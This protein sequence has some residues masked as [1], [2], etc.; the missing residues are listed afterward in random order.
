MLRPYS[1]KS[2]LA[3]LI[4]VNF[5]LLSG[6]ILSSSFVSAVDDTVIDDINISI[7]LAC[8]INGSG[9]GS[10][11]A[12]INNGTYESDIGT[13]TI[14]AFCNDNEGFSIYA[15]GY[16]DNS[17]GKNVLS[18]VSLGSTYDIATG[19]GTSG[20]SQW[21]VKLATN[22][23]A[24]YPITLQNNYGAYHTIPSDYELVA[25]RTSNT[26][27]GQ[28]AIGA[29]LS[30]TYQVFISDSQP[31]GRYVGKVKYVMVHPHDTY[32]GSKDEYEVIYDGSGST[33]SNGDRTNK[34]VYEEECDTMYERTAPTISKTSNMDNEG[35]VISSLTEN[36]DTL[37]PIT[38]SGANMLKI[39]L[40]YNAGDSICLGVSE[41]FIDDWDY[42]KCANGTYDYYHHYNYLTSGGSAIKTFY[43]DGD[44]VTFDFVSSGQSYSSNNNWGYF[45]QVYPIYETQRT[46]TQEASVCRISST[47]K[48]GTYDTTVNWQ[49]QWYLN[50]NG[51]EIITFNSESDVIE[52]LEINQPNSTGATIH[53]YAY[54]PYY[55]TYDGNNATA[56]NMSTYSQT[57]DYSFNE[58]T[59][60]A[61]NFYKTNYGF[62]GWS[63][64]PNATVN[65]VNKIFGPNETIA[66]SELKAHN[67]ILYAV[68]VQTA[69]TLQ[70]WSG[71][72]GLSEGQVTALTDSRDGQTYAVAK[73]DDGNCW[74][75]E[76]L[77]LEATN[78][79]D[80]TKAQGFGGGFSGLANPETSNFSNTSTANSKYSSSNI[81]STNRSYRFPRYNNTNITF[82]STSPASNDSNIYG[83]GNYYT[84]AAAK[85]NISDLAS[86]SDSM[87][88]NTSICPSGW[89]LPLT[90]TTN[91][92]YPNNI[93]YSGNINGSTISSRG[94]NGYYWLSTVSSARNADS[95]VRVQYN[96][97]GFGTIGQK[98]YGYS[99]RCMMS[100]S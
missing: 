64:N 35:N 10:H 29:T 68:W 37:D 7:P 41:S 96:D 84:W 24:T 67:A 91:P 51:P 54:Y 32:K 86:R 2:F 83:Y 50:V 22:S 92:E 95:I 48:S 59:L 94:S 27:V 97:Y 44:T 100:G 78:S 13:T 5:T 89:R 19:T 88:A 99:V 63:E 18:S 72:S 12:T 87:A 46:G 71:C 81:S 26:D 85:A 11:T 93:V 28:G 75:I 34:V 60:T 16:T 38:I 47:P 62:A 82:L 9:M 98:Y 56:G 1:N 80:G 4:L 30:T 52:Y 23:G 33:F 61:P 65:S 8:T 21:A 73:L 3:A 20:N 39:V 31:A 6:F 25:K 36:N 45:A 79:S 57:I 40:K 42:S 15:I 66:G 14:Q 49:G 58:V 43:I 76:N 69:G 55:I 90:Y 74:M 53:L 77:R 70:G 17:H